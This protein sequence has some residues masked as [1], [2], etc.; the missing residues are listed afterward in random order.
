MRTRAAR[1][2]A[3]SLGWA[4]L[5]GMHAASMVALSAAPAHAVD[6]MS[7]LG[8]PPLG[9]PAVPVPADNPL[10]K[11]KV[12]LGR[13]L[14]FDP[15][16][17]SVDGSVAC[18]SCHSPGLGWSNGAPVAV[19][20]MGQ[21]GGRSAPVIYNTAYESLLF[22]DGRSNSLEDQAAGPIQNPIEMGQGQGNLP[23]VAK[24]LNAIPS[25]RAMFV[26]VF[27]DPATPQN[28]TRAIAS[29]E[30]T[31][32]SG[33]APIDRFQAGDTKALSE[34]A[35]RGWELFKGKAN[36]TTCHVGFNF[37]DGDFHNLGVGMNKKKP[38]LGR[39]EVTKKAE[40]KGKF[41]T[42]T[43][44]EITESAPYMHDGSIATLEEVVELYDRGGDKNPNLDQQIVA[45]HL[46]NAEKADLVA[47]L[48]EG[49]KGEQ[50][51]IVF[52]ELPK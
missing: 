17:L 22:W 4:V 46:S 21:K 45:L 15:R 23:K 41:R 39:H 31:I 29:Y 19:G 9:L 7:Y 37:A 50:L 25:Y 38:D 3:I 28:I 10:T 11:A 42:M 12:E 34:Q 18:A 35:Q 8:K 30:R 33:N 36:C 24:R 14:Y 48:K 40:D 47:F 1:L 52:P 2:V 26:K 43:L 6:P 13:A 44:R 51:T 16:V 27:K 20:V 32:L 5:V 49:L